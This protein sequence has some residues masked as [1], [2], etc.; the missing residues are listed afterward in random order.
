MKVPAVIPSNKQNNIASNNK[1]ISLTAVKNNNTMDT[2]DK[3]LETLK[4]DK[5]K[6][7]DIRKSSPLNDIII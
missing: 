1:L 6:K 4:P 2:L 7:H 5:V 3:I